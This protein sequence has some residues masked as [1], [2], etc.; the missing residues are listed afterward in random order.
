MTDGVGDVAIKREHDPRAGRTIVFLTLITAL[1]ILGA[2]N[3]LTEIAGQPFFGLAPFLVKDFLSIFVLAPLMAALLALLLRE[4]GGVGPASMFF[5]V[6]LAAVLG[7][8]MGLHDFTN[9]M[10]RTGV[11]RT[12]FHDA[13]VFLDDDLSHW[14]FFVAYAGLSLMVILAQVRRPLAEPL[15]RWGI[16]A[17]T[18]NAL[19]LAA[20]TFANLAPESK[21][22]LDLVVVFA[23]LAAAF[24]MRLLA[25]QPLRRLPVSWY[26]ESGFGIALVASIV[27]KTL[28]T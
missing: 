22:A 27:Y 1:V 7:A 15:S 8:S 23:V 14:T 17:V 20:M 9:A 16:V 28:L 10:T 11:E 6:F 3:R 4:Y 19:V 24:A 2:V 21:T 26:F 5:F 18:A 13:I 12:G 25:K